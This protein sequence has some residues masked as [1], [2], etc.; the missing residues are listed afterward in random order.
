MADLNRPNYGSAWASAGEKVAPDL[1]KFSLGWV[2][3]MMPYQY[4]N[5]LQARQDEAILYLLQ[6]GI[7]EYSPTQEYTANKS[8]V[9][10][11]G[12][13]YLATQTVT[14]VLPT[15]T[16]SW[17]RVSTISDNSGVVSVAGGGT[18]ATT[19]AQARTNLGLGTAAT[20][21]AA[22]VVQKDVNGDFTANVIT[23]SLAG[24]ASTADKWETTRTIQLNGAATSSSANIDGS[25]NVVVSVTTLDASTLTGD[26]PSTSLVN[27]VVKTSATGAAKLPK[28]TTAQRP[29]SPEFGDFRANETTRLVEYWNGSA[30]VNPSAYTAEYV[31]NRANHTGFQAISTVTGLEDALNSK[32][33]LSGGTLSGNLN[34]PSLNGGQ[35]AG[36]RNKIINGSFRVWQRGSGITINGSDTYTADRWFA[37]AAGANITASKVDYNAGNASSLVITGAASN[38]KC[39][40]GQRIEGVNTEDLAGKLVTLSCE[41]FL[42]DGGNVT[43]EARYANAVDNFTTT[44]LISSGTITVT[45]TEFK[46]AAVNFTVP[47]AFAHHGIEIRFK[48]GALTAT[49][50]AALRCVQ[51]E[52]GEVATPFEH[53]PIGV[54]L[55]LCQR[56]YHVSNAVLSSNN[57]VANA[58]RVWFPVTMRALPTITTT[59]YSGSGA[60]FGPNT[61]NQ[62]AAQ[63]GIHSVDTSAGLTAS[64]EL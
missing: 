37:V 14:N 52:V 59:P 49:K 39:D 32:L 20:L 21:D 4:E 48:Y 61:G 51:L 1:S 27:A 10:Y 56:Y 60:T 36:M 57:A 24:N 55:S 63:S 12:V 5:Y 38:T 16:A 62:S 28:G 9:L 11:N 54:E 35:I 43:W 33:R 45:G 53:R 26:V 13:V 47:P 46:F 15:V 50:Q 64:A 44:T 6:K 25:S 22:N 42:T 29:A 58:N 2:Q 8:L 3:E 41:V 23:A 31:L 7:P 18:G 19:Q 34:V 40:I 30:W 17:K